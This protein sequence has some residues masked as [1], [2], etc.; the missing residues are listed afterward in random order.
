MDLLRHFPGAIRSLVNDSG[1]QLE[2]AI[3]L[4][5]SLLVSVFMYGSET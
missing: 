5:K 3:V 4:H 1:L 2:C